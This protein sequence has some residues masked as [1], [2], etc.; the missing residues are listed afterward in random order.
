MTDELT[1][2]H[3]GHD[4]D[5]LPMPLQPVLAATTLG[6]LASDRGGREGVSM[7][8]AGK[9][10]NVLVERTDGLAR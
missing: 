2:R 8:R 6:S 1:G 4:V 10:G 3:P 9:A 7:N 5:P